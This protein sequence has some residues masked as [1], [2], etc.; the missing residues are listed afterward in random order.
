M[1]Q[2]SWITPVREP[3]PRGLKPASSQAAITAAIILMREPYPRGLKQID[4]LPNLTQLLPELS[5]RT[6]ST[7]IETLP[8][9]RFREVDKRA[10]T[11]STGIETLNSPPSCST[12]RCSREPY[13]RGLKRVSPEN[14]R[15]VIFP[16]EPY[17]RGLKPFSTYSRA[18][19]LRI[20]REPYPRGLKPSL[21]NE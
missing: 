1:T 9:T 17:P 2:K 15:K 12:S 19:P 10:R 6:L 20:T 14:N 7:G 4:A 11:L 21:I 5:A 13:P 16:R 8:L 3:Y 18:S